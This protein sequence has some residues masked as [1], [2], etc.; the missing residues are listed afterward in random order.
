[1][2]MDATVHVVDDDV[3]IRDALKW[4]LKSRGLDLSFIQVP[5]RSW[6]RSSQAR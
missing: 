1:M 3:G 4:L 6:K 5:K 2:L